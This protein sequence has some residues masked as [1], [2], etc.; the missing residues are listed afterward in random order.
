MDSI[1]AL[2]QGN[3]SFDEL[4]DF[5]EQICVI[6]KS[7]EFI[8]VNQAWKTLV[9]AECDNPVLLQVGNYIDACYVEVHKGEVTLKHVISQLSKLLNGESKDIECLFAISL[10]NLR[11]WFRMKGVKAT[12]ESRS[13]YV[14]AHCDIT[15]DVLSGAIEWD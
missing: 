4:E 9:D 8:F 3:H 6:N 11:R 1:T 2:N 13:L 14:L 7:G 10:G 12:F 5:D 15:S